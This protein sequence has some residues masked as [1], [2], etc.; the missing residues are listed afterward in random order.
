MYVGVY[1]FIENYYDDIHET[2]HSFN[3]YLLSAC[4]VPG[5]V[6][7]A[8]EVKSLFSWSNMRRI[9]TLQW[10][11]LE[12][13]ASRGRKQTSHLNFI[14]LFEILC[15]YL[16]FPILLRAKK[17]FFNCINFCNQKNSSRLCFPIRL[18]MIQK[19]ITPVL[20]RIWGN[21]HPQTLGVFDSKIFFNQ[22]LLKVA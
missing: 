17:Y 9:L 19:V 22:N 12:R 3:K 2:A 14:V 8:G 15:C 1:I 7:Y 18:A 5:I 20:V 13:G 6:L 16:M 21:R 4:Y 11:T 10:V